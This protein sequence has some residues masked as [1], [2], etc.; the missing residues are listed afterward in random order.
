MKYLIL[1]SLLY[2]I[3]TAKAQISDSS[4]SNSTDIPNVFKFQKQFFFLDILE[5]GWLNAP[6]N[7]EAKVFSGG[8]NLNLLYE[9]NIIP[10]LLSIA[11]GISY[12]V[13]TVKTNAKYQYIFNS[14]SSE[15]LFTNLEQVNPL[16]YEKSKL[17]TST[18]GI[19]VE[20]HIYTKANEK[21]RGFL[22]A[23][24]FRAGLLA[25]D[26]WKFKYT[27]EQPGQ[28][29]IKIYGIENLSSFNYGLSLR[30]MYYKFG[31]YGYYSM[32]RLF[33]KGKGPDITPV[34]LGFT[35]SPF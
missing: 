15:I 22:I 25:G 18:I 32:S 21:G 5:N 31:I 6:P 12:S 1:F 20:L 33:E 27:G 11:P 35:L 23:P 13:T 34:S 24:G 16:L 28:S 4:A 7:I 8:F 2:S 26:F 3:A 29:K 19:P 30:L 17:S 14:D 10:S 9:I